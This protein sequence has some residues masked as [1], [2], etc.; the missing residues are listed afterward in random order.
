ME[1]GTEKLSV[2]LVRGLMRL[3]S[4]LPLPLVQAI[5][6]GIGW[7]LATVP[8]RERRIAEAN[9]EACFPGKSG[10]E[11]RALR[12]QSLVS[13]GKLFAEIPAAWFRSVDYW[14]DRISSTELE[15]R[16]GE[17]LSRGKGLIAAA[18]HLGNWEIGVQRL[19]RVAPVTV[20]Y[21]SPRQSGVEAIMVAGRGIGGAKL[22]PATRRGVREVSAA[23]RRGEM[24]AI[25]PDQTPKVSD[26][27][28]AGV[29][30]PFFGKPALTMTL[31]SRL[32]LKSG[33]PVLFVYARRIG[34]GR[35]RGE[36]RDAPPGVDSVDLVEAATALNVGVETCVR[37]CPEQYLWTYKRFSPSAPGDPWIYWRKRKARRK[38]GL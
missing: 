33:A 18:P 38:A 16:A 35:F 23:L 24:V 34:G 15:Q 6:G 4:R 29:Y 31:V 17:L 22:V 25:L 37:R 9:I 3:W 27:R 36:F 32:A 7:V 20:L 2:R 14:D 12:K 28:G 13:S 8:N 21:R 19:A 30:A 26:G 10:K 5:G 1:T 11:Q